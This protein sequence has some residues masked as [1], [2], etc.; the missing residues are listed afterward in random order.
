[1]LF[2]VSFCV[3]SCFNYFHQNRILL[4]YFHINLM[5][6]NLLSS[7]LSCSKRDVPEEKVHVFNFWQKIVV[8]ISPQEVFYCFKEPVIVIEHH[9]NFVRQTLG[10]ITVAL[11]NPIFP[12]LLQIITKIS[13]EFVKKFRDSLFI[14][15]ITKSGDAF[16]T[17]VCDLPIWSLNLV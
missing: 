4:P 11:I 2:H 3:C 15:L 6:S 16:N 7:F 9:A 12:C 13:E 10:K 8:F 5:C 14:S 17:E 1:M